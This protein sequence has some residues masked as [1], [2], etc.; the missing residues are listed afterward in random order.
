[1]NSSDTG[2]GSLR[3]ILSSATTGETIDFDISLN[4]QTI[5]LASELVVTNS[6]IIDAS[7][8]SSGII[9]S[10]NSN[11]DFTHDFGET[12]CFLISDGD[13]ASTQSVHLI[14][15]TIHGGVSEGRD[16]A[17]IQS[18]ED[19]TLSHC[20][21]T[22]GRMID[23]FKS[24]GAGIH[25]EFGHLIVNHSTISGHQCSADQYVLGGAIHVKD[26]KLTMTSSTITE[27][28]V[29][30]S[31][32][33]L[34]IG[35]YSQRSRISLTDCLISSNQFNVIPG[36]SLSYGKGGGIFITD[37]EL[38]VS[39]STIKD[40]YADEGGGVYS[41]D[42]QFQVIDSVIDMNQ[43]NR[44][45]GG[46]YSIDSELEMSR[47]Q[48]Q[49][50]M[51][52]GKGGGLESKGGQLIADRCVFSGNLS[53]GDGGAINSDS[54]LLTLKESTISGN[55]ASGRGGGINSVDGQ[56]TVIKSTISGNQ[57]DSHGGGVSRDVNSG[58][59][60][61]N[62]F[63]WLQNS[64]VSNNQSDR[65]GG[66]LY[67][68]D[69]LFRVEHC[70]VV[71]NIASSG[72]G[73][74]WSEGTSTSLEFLGSVVREN[75]DEDLIYEDGTI[76]SLGGNFIGTG[77]GADP[78]V[79]S[80]STDILDSTNPL[81]LGPLTNNGGF[82]FT[83]MPMP[84]SPLVDGA[85]FSSYTSDQRNVSRVIPDIGAVE[86]D[87]QAVPPVVNLS[88]SSLLGGCGLA[89]GPITVV[90]TP[91][92]TV[93]G[94]IN[95]A[96]L[97]DGGGIIQSISPSG[98]LA[99]SGLSDGSYSIHIVAAEIASAA[100]V[101]L[102]NITV[103][104]SL[105]S[106][107]T[108]CLAITS[109]YI[110]CCHVFSNVVQNANDS[111]FGSLRCILAEANS[112]ATITFLPS[113]SGQTISL[114]SELVIDKSITIDASM[115]TGPDGIIIRGISSGDRNV[116]V[117]E[118]RCF[119]VNDQNSAS[120]QA[121]HFI[122]LTITSGSARF[123]GNI[124]S[125]EALTLTN[126]R[127]TDGR[128]SRSGGGIYSGSRL[129]LNQT[130]ISANQASFGG[131]VYQNP[132]CLLANQSTISGNQAS[133]RGGG[134]RIYATTL[135][136]I[137]QQCTITDNYADDGGAFHLDHATQTRLEHCTIVENR[138]ISSAGGVVVDTANSLT[139][140]ELLG[141]V[142][143]DNGS[144]DLG[145]E[146][147]ATDPVSL[148]GNL[149]GLGNFSAS[150]FTNAT[151][152]MDAFTPL[153]LGTL[154]DNGGPTLTMLPMPG[155]PL[156]DGAGSTGAI[157]DQRGEV[158]PRGYA[159]DIGA[160]E[161]DCQS[162]QSF[163]CP[164]NVTGI[165][166]PSFIPPVTSLPTV[167][168]SC[169][170]APVIGVVTQQLSGDDCAGTV[171]YIFTAVNSFGN[172]TT[173][174]QIFTYAD[175]TAPVITSCPANV[176]VNGGSALPTSPEAV[177]ATDNCG[178]VTV[179][180]STAAIPGGNCQSVQH[181][182]YTA[183]DLCGNA[184]SCTQVV[185]VI[186]G[187]VPS[188]SCPA[189]VTGLMCPSLIPPVTS[190][191][192]VTDSCDPA[193]VIGVVTQQLSGDDCAGTVG[194]IFTAVNSF[195]NSTTCTQTFT[196]A[197]TTAPVI[198]SCPA[199]VTMNGGSAPPTSPEAVVATDNCGSVTVSVSTATIPGGSC[200]SVQHYIYTATDLCGNTA[201]CTQVV[202]VINASVPS[203][204]CPANVT[205]LTCPGLIPPV[206]SLPTVTDSCDP[207]PVIGVV[208][209]QL[210]GDS[211]AGTVGY[212]F[213]AVNSFG[214]STTC[215]Q[216]FAY[217]DTTAPV[218]SGCPEHVTI[219]GMAS[220]PNN[221]GISATDN[222]TPS[223]ELS[224]LGVTITTNSATP[225]QEVLVYTYSF[226][227]ACGNIGSCQQ[228]VTV[229]IPSIPV[230]FCPIPS[231]PVG[232]RANVPGPTIPTASD[233]CNL[234]VVVGVVTQE[235]G[236]A[237]AGT[238]SYLYTAMNS[239]GNITNCLQSYSYGDNSAP[240][241]VVPTAVAILAGSLTSPAAIGS[242]SGIS[243]NC[244]SAPLATFSDT[245]IPSGA[246][247]FTRTWTVTDA[248][249]NQAVGTQ[250]VT[251]LPTLSI[252]DLQLSASSA[253]TFLND[254]N[255]T[256]HIQVTNAGRDPANAVQVNVTIPPG[257]TAGNLPAGCALQ[258]GSVICT[259]PVLANGDILDL[260]I[261]FVLD[262]SSSTSVVNYIVV[263]S[264]VVDQN[265]S[266]NTASTIAIVGD[267][268]S[269]G[270]PDFA[271]PDN[272]GDGIPN[273]WEI[274]HNL[275]PED[276]S[277]ATLDRDGDNNTA[278]QEYIADTDPN[279]AGSFLRIASIRVSS[280]GFEISWSA[281]PSRVYRI[282]RVPVLDNTVG[283]W[284]DFTSPIT[285]EDGDMTFVVD[286]LAATGPRMNYRVVVDL[287]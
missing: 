285:G 45:G 89:D 144:A 156:I 158:R 244:D 122:N 257:T 231:G 118:T 182:I 14:N 13:N 264:D 52:A 193:P 110:S 29:M 44:S 73:G 149:V 88:A 75:T 79:F 1:M 131:G 198:T 38:D 34:G 143:R 215:T 80:N 151:D 76:V 207:A 32:S 95:T 92:T 243:D 174:T 185:T 211:C 104:D 67:N 101:D 282:Q 187:S 251:L 283:T 10:G 263:S 195:G 22:G 93:A 190:L 61:S 258:A 9:I 35:I 210:N 78:S 28:S 59:A 241:F 100:G 99:S 199:N 109:L 250:F 184:A 161:L 116:D 196:Y 183:T 77:N 4:G 202:T 166:C 5:S 65:D 66:G 68:R 262:G 71:E 69:G 19:L 237:C 167:T 72:G 102:S 3:D 242:P 275:D 49:N 238:V 267:R 97:V 176:T 96:L 145:V 41:E 154:A 157:V 200:Q 21:V 225:C 260:A 172:S 135:L 270:I 178:S 234:S 55:T 197:D 16:G 119:F 248:C 186:N 124:F 246:G 222:C 136:N 155:S 179:S 83:H 287:P 85:S 82:T 206:T 194:Y 33:G 106:I 6:L 163:S 134:V 245:L 284:T 213:T 117:G 253:P 57:S 146:G 204:S 25:S 107:S 31:F 252:V 27:N 108:D 159:P 63:A 24:G 271:D 98:N 81:L 84:G 229:L 188:I 221:S 233:P 170:P 269:D 123:G 62:E 54:D 15:L 181:Y 17:N 239:F 112:G 127:I 268:D 153:L 147:F 212:I 133:V 86:A 132:G 255:L 261:P 171:G 286:S 138:A 273:A 47:S 201:S 216:T 125:R 249:G 105:A 142:I 8:L 180:V 60:S 192:T 137:L 36:S 228:I 141:T 205:G 235:T 148:G 278:L 274:L 53:E 140:L 277:D 46:I 30:N 218:L 48:I 175:T 224:S 240:S 139:S 43:A 120:T 20:L 130:D 247:N 11:G 173:C 276:E 2:S 91:R 18:Q 272:D 232:C 165:T 128:A 236:D 265:T 64:T 209:Q 214:N 220:P 168:D 115:L 42:S 39:S 40:N 23:S 90:F 230:M 227:D 56:L 70:T 74:V 126:C 177:V 51:A 279:A 226:A 223:F 129:N 114:A 266:D 150:V 152:Q 113:L 164:A 217:A 281:Q 219:V 37:S 162:I 256:V 26:G 50:N 189:N 12:R 121:V 280:V 208:T 160:L 7:S 58:S 111:G 259:C 87:C 94:Y 169:D 254:S 203:I 103:G 191:P